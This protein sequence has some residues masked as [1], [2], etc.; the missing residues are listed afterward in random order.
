MVRSE[1][2]EI[3]RAAAFLVIVSGPPGAGKTTIAKQLGGALRLPV[4]DRDDLKDSLF[5][6]LGWS[7]REWSKRV[8]LASWR[9]LFLFVDLAVTQGVSMVLDSN[10]E[11]GRHPELAGLKERTACTI[12]EVHCN[13]DVNVL[14][15]RFRERWESGGRHPGHTDVYTNEDVYI[16]ELG[17]R[18]FIP[19]E[20]SDL[21]IRVDTTTSEPVDLDG[22]VNQIRRIADGL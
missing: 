17:A 2:V 5:D 6:S 18:S 19:L 16:A 12:I 4:L 14:A 10:F 13:G 11:R 9:L 7:D 22:I 15:R 20:H 8:G 3:L 1:R 21:V